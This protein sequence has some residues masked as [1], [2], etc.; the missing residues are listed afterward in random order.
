ML[1]HDNQEYCDEIVEVFKKIPISENFY[2]FNLT[3]TI[4]K[5][6]QLEDSDTTRA[7]N[8]KPHIDKLLYENAIGRRLVAKWFNRSKNGIFNPNQLIDKGYYNVSAS[9]VQTALLSHKTQ[10]GVIYDAGEELIGKTYILVNDISYGDKRRNKEKRMSA[11]MALSA[12]PIIG[13]VALPVAGIM[14]NDYS[15][16]NVTVTS[17]LYRLDWTKEISDVFYSVYYTETPDDVKKRAFA[18][19]KGLFTVHFIGSQ[20]VHSSNSN[21]KGVNNRESQI[22]KICTRAIDKAIAQLQKKHPEFRVSTPLIST[23]PIRAHIGVREDVTQD[24]KFEV[25]EMSENS[26]GIQSYKRV[27]VI[28]PKPGKIWD[29][30]YMAEFEEHKNGILDATEFEIVSGSISQTVCLIREI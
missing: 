19:E 28:K 13:M 9:D 15:G 22:R 8:Q 12:I 3:N 26:E 2:D 21:F 30:R 11:A 7:D 4:F 14:A 29:N 17:Y 6:G 5:A 24:S 23:T 25:L 18:S 20:T 10:E 16:F 1:K 27:A